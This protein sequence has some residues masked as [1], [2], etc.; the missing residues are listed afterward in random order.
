MIDF[1]QRGINID[2][3]FR[4]TL[5]CPSCM[6]ADY[7]RKNMKIPGRDMPLSDFYK[8]ADFFK[9]VQFCGQISDPIFNPNII[10]ML[11]YCYVNNVPVLVNTAASQRKNI[12]MKKLLMQ[13]QKQGG[14][15]VLMVCLKIVISTE[16]IKTENT[17]LK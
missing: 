17:Y 5:E 10:E 7:K 13:I 1:R 9:S 16:F 3:S 4:C 15:L 12:G 6:R 2:T 14:F 11:R 8:I